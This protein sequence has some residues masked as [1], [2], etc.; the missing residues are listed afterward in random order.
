MN[1][2]SIFIDVKNYDNFKIKST[3][4]TIEDK[5]YDILNYDKTVVCFNDVQNSRYKNV[6]LSHPEKQVLSV[7]PPKN[8]PFS[9]FKKQFPEMHQS[10]HN[11]FEITEFIDG[12]IINL[13]YDN[14][15]Q[16]WELVTKYKNAKKG[17]ILRQYSATYKEFVQLVRGPEGADI[18]TLYCMNIFNKKSTYNFK[19]QNDRLY[20]ISVYQIKHMV[21]NVAICN[22]VKQNTTL[23]LQP[24]IGII[25]YP[26]QFHFYDYKDMLEKIEN[27]SQY[28]NKFIITHSSGVQTTLLTTDCEFVQKYNSVPR[29]IQFL[30]LCVKR[31]NKNFELTDLY[32][33]F[34][35]QFITVDGL[36]S[37]FIDKIHT[38]YVHYY[39]LKDDI[40]K[41]CYMF[42]AHRIHKE[43]YIPSLKTQKIKIHKE[44]IRNYFTTKHPRELL[45]LLQHICE[46]IQ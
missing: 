14:R 27:D 37:D 26:K 7:M 9:Y 23:E 13:F 28:P 22:I 36:Y 6:I 29:N 4:V 10:I 8:I 2:Y 24:L 3:I 16:K 39:I 33:R 12:P 20:L 40:Y 18:N 41:D 43:V 42:W 21:N 44:V 30:Y 35:N 5:L 38:A 19:I 11:H 45:Y 15:T 34:K 31:I 32:P 17:Y 25:S 46:N 1:K